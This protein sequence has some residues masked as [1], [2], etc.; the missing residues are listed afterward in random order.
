M[1]LWIPIV[2]LFIAG[3]RP[4]SLWLSPTQGDLTDRY[5]EGSPLDRNFFALLIIAALVVLFKRRNRIRAFLRANGPLL[6]FFLYCGVSICW[7][8]FRDVAF[9]RWIRAVGDLAMISVVITDREPVAAIKGFL[10]RTGFLLLPLSVF[11]DLV[12]G[13]VGR[14]YHFGLTTNK[15]MF[16]GISMVLGLAAIWRFYVTLQDRERKNRAKRL[17]AHGSLAAVA[18]WCLL[19]ANSGTS[20][21]GFVLGTMIIVLTSR[22][23]FFQ[24][25]A[26]LHLMVASLLFFAV[27]VSILN[28]NFGIVASMGKDPTLTG[29]TDVWPIVLSLNPNPWVGAGFESF[30]LGSRLRTLW[31]IFPWR[32]NEA[33]NGYIEMYINIGW[34]GLLLLAL[35]MM[36]GYGKIVR[37][38]QE[39][40]ETASL[41]LAYFVVALVYN[42]TEAGFRIFNPVWLVCLLSA[43]FFVKGQSTSKRVQVVT[44]GYW[45]I[46][47]SLAE[48]R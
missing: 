4:I 1:S 24:R 18:A 17:L 12:R 19:T 42:L 3:S 48:S 46:P 47:Q 11:F 41:R 22:F 10:A 28:P 27:Y 44:K 34:I 40:K 33:H 5:L 14:E 16:G 31:E 6:L 15:N 45:D 21:A 20:T 32:P 9:K 2:W 37:G 43:A 26:L 29:R 13:Q 25:P 35:V 38:F 8:D 36:D 23:F 7:S 30:W 39:D